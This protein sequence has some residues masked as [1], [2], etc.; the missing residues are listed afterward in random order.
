MSQPKDLLADEE[1]A[2]Y[3]TKLLYQDFGPWSTRV[4]ALLMNIKL[5]SNHKRT[6]DRSLK[7]CEY[8]MQQIEGKDVPIKQRFSHMFATGINPKWI[9]E[10]RLGDL[11]LSL[12]MVKTSL[13]LYLRLQLWEEVI[14]CYTMLD[15]RHKVCVRV[16]RNVFIMFSLFLLL[17]F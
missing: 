16:R 3:I 15:L 4:S 14:V 13:D 9:V 12:G 2:P 17:F 5:E 6:V 10:A 1:L 7:Q 8:V 11:M